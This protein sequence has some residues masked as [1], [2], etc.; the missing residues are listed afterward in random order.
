MRK[1]KHFVKQSVLLSIC[2]ASLALA[3]VC[4][5]ICAWL[6]GL[7]S[8]QKEA[9]RWQG[10]GETG[11]SQVSCFLPVDAKI[12]L[13]Q[14]GSFRTA[15]MKK[16][17]DASLDVR[18]EEQLMSDAW[19]T[20]AELKAVS[21]HGNGTAACIA[22]GGSFFDFHPLRLLS[23]DY[24][25]QTDLMQDR[26]LLDENLAWLLFGGTE[27]QGMSIKLNGVPFA[28]AGVVEREQDFASR[29]A[30]ET[31][32]RLF[33]RYDALLQID[34]SAKIDCYECVVAEPV[35]GFAVNA[36]R[37]KF[38]IGR[39][40]ILCNTTRYE[41]QKLMNLVRDFGTRST[42]ATGVAYPYWENAARIIEDWAGLCC[43][44]GTA[45]AGLAAATGLAVLIPI[46][47]KGRTRL[48]EDILPD[49][50]ERAEEAVRVRQRKRWE[51]QHPDSREKPPSDNERKQT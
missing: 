40:V 37:E 24:I 20:S 16:L 33:M 15:M 31:E 27:L 18:G 22:V 17:Q 26:V 7:L 6:T 42:Q 30:D 49:A 8:S 11:F 32:L 21:D 9:E 50:V 10:D 3:A 12:T 43:V 19:S 2:A 36:V 46:L 25:R 44:L 39:G 48:E 13:N 14:I 4:A 5:G 29:K 1:K 47:Q 34:D 28:V 23:G 38:P 51:R 45:L 41:Y 35:R